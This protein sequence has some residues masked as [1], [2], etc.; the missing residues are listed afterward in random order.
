MDL[1]NF[2]VIL[3]VGGVAGWIATSLLKR[4]DF[5]L[6]GNI[7]IGVIGAFLGRS[8]FDV[9]DIYVYGLKGDIIE[10]VVGAIA[11]LFILGLLKRR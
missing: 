10:A 6:V 8:L 4:R 3:I 2:I 11:L 5:G 9:L 1:D 7:V